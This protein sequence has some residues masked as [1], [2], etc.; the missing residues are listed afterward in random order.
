MKYKPH[1]TAISVRD[2]DKSVDFYKQF[3]FEQVH[4]YDETD[5]SMSI[6]HLKLGDYH[7]ELFWYRDNLTAAKLQLK[8]SDSL[9][10][11]GV[12]HIALQVD[13]VDAILEGLKSKGVVDDS[14]EVVHGR[15][16]V[17]YFFVQDPDGMWV[18]ILKDDRH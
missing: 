8:H 9:K 6:V 17:H 1:H 7:L 11:I 14:T 10:K 12:K 5:N 13:D 18:E 16:K 15:T 4:R 2:I 3:G